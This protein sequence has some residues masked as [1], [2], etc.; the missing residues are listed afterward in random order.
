MDA[1]HKKDGVWLPAIR[2]AVSV[3]FYAML[4][5]FLLILVLWHFVLNNEAVYHR[6]SLARGTVRQDFRLNYSGYYRMGIE[7][8][9]KFPHRTLQCLL[10][11]NDFMP[12]DG[13]KDT[14]AVLKY[15]WTLSCEGGRMT[16]SGSSEKIIGGAYTKDTM[17][18]EFG[19]FQGKWGERC[20]L[21][22]NFLQDANGTLSVANPKLHIYTELF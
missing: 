21:A 7:V 8:E 6:I 17:E 9:R 5:C 15:F 3:I 1:D 10:G 20:R 19:G 11:V 18:V 2:K 12:K 14:P 22:V 4:L 16:E 13:C